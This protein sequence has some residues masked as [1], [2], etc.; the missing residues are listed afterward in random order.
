MEVCTNFEETLNYF[1]PH[2]ILQFW[3]SLLVVA[4][5][6]AQVAHDG[7]AIIVYNLG[8]GE[9]NYKQT[10]GCSFEMVIK[11]KL[12]N[13]CWLGHQ[14]RQIWCQQLSRPADPETF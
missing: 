5:D 8:P 10:A 4:A 11:L 7:L 9:K 13:T 2:L 12:S 3:F 14:D 6:G 1:L